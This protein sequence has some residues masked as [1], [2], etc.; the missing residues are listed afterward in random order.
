MKNILTSRKSFLLSIPLTG[1]II[2]ALLVAVKCHA[3]TDSLR[4]SSPEIRMAYVYYEDKGNVPEPDLYNRLIYAFGNFNE[5]NDGIIIPT[6]HKLHALADLKKQNPE[7]KV[8][9]GIG[10]KKYEGFSEMAGNK[11]KRAKFLKSL[12]TILDTLNL[13]GVDYDWEYPG[14]TAGGH[15]AS[16]AD[17][18][19]Y[20]TLLKETRK[21]LGKDKLISFF[22]SHS[23]YFLDLKNMHQYVDCV[24]LPGYD[25]SI[26]KEGEKAK[27]QSPLYPSKKYGEWCI[28]KSLSRHLKAG[29]PR[30][31]ILL[32][33][34]FYGRGI[35]P[36]PPTAFAYQMAKFTDG[37]ILEWD[38]DAK[39]P[40][41]MNPEGDLVFTFDNERSIREKCEYIRQQGLSGAFIWHYDADFPDH[42]LSKSLQS[43]T[44]P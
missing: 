18:K 35:S 36:F 39:V 34:P 22:S 42:R 8:I 43:L 29:I 10:G 2:I 41:Y 5:S 16:P 44:K 13:D 11:K 17:E 27:H 7:L 19:N 37:S 25:L 12:K 26:P 4:N 30:E 38:E 1:L 28:D 31:K 15:S 23:G 20:I 24:N 40:Y 14:T 9:L 21:K 33:I 3:Q 32:G 6:P